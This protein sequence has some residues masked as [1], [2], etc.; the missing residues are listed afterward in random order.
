[1][2]PRALVAGLQF[3]RRIVISPYRV[4]H[5]AIATDDRNPIHFEQ[6]AAEALGL[7]GPIAHGD[8]IV[9]LAN[10]VIVDELPGVMIEERLHTQFI[11]TILIGSTIV[12]SATLESVTR[13][14]G[15]GPSHLLLVFNID[16]TSLVGKICIRSSAKARL[17]VES[18]VAELFSVA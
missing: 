7:P 8:L 11:R 13:G 17:Y 3:S 10:A 18:S 12:I 5:F 16:F 14:A 9:P 6:A 1:M 4:E 2:D 15:R